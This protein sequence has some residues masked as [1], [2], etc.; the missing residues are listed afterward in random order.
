MDVLCSCLHN[1]I[2]LAVHVRQ[3]EN[4]QKSPALL[5]IWHNNTC[6]K[7]SCFIWKQKIFFCLHLFKLFRNALYFIWRCQNED[8][9]LSNSFLWLVFWTTRHAAVSW[10]LEIIFRNRTHSALWW[11]W[12][13]HCASLD[14]RQ[15]LRCKAVSLANVEAESS[16]SSSSSC[17]NWPWKETGH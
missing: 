13:R 6:M 4:P 11:C 9:T 8:Q 7:N 12:T 3:D 17:V 14:Q 15:K 1:D 5:R 10:V 2:L 16:S